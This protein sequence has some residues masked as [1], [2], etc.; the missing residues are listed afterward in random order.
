MYGVNQGQLH[1]D[2]YLNGVWQLDVTPPKIGSSGNL[3]VKQVVDLNAFNGTTVFFRFRGLTGGGSKC[4]MALDDLS[5]LDSTAASGIMD[6]SSSFS[7]YPNPAS[8]FIEI[9]TSQLSNSFDEIFIYDAM[10][11]MV[12]QEGLKSAQAQKQIN[13]SRY[14]NG[15]YWLVLKNNHQVIY[16]N[17]WL[18]N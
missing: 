12:Y 2:A 16:K 15:I 4:D 13:I 11:E 17:K 1:L 7:I 6:R 18:K 5:V 14:S 3:W 8:Q 9:K 10:G